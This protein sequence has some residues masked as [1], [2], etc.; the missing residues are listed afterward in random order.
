MKKNFKNSLFGQ[1]L[2]ENV[3][4]LIQSLYLRMS[5]ITTKSSKEEKS[6]KKKKKE[7]KKK[8]KQLPT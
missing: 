4:S 7:K 3:L 8:K 1:L 2:L 6:L 5:F